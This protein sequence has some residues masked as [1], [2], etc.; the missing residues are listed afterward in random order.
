M[1]VVPLAAGVYM[2]HL[3]L[4]PGVLGGGV[5]TYV[6]SEHTMGSAVS[7]YLSWIWVTA[8]DG[9]HEGGGSGSWFLGLLV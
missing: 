7:H 3:V 4:S 8:R 2:Q 5:A 6:Y 1:F 9:V